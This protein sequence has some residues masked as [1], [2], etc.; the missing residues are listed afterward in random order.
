MNLELF[1]AGMTS[2]R[3]TFVK[4]LLR[5]NGG[6]VFSG[7]EQ[8]T[9]SLLCN[10]AIEARVIGLEYYRVGSAWNYRKYTGGDN[11]EY[12]RDCLAGNDRN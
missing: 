1:E 5:K 12:G 2:E 4:S 7:E 10:A 8:K 9:A 3:T 11:A 6:M